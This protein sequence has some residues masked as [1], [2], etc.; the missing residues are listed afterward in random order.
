MEGRDA[1]VVLRLV[2]AAAPALG[3]RAAPLR[4]GAHQG[5]RRGRV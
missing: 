3:A 5:A 1:D 2:P 4:A